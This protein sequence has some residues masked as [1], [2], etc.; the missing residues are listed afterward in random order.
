[1][2]TRE[3]VDA[4]SF[5]LP[6]GATASGD[7]IAL[8]IGLVPVDVYLDF[9]CP[10]CK[11]FQ[12]MSGATLEG[13]LGDGAITLVHHPVNLLDAVSTTGYSTRAAAA[14]AAASDF[15]RFLEYVEALLL[16]QPPED[17]PGLT[18]CQL[19]ELGHAVGI[20]DA[21][22]AERVN[23]GRYLPWPPYVTE[24]ATRR[25]VS[26]TPTVYVHGKP[27]AARPGPIELA[28]RIRI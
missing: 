27:V 2:D 8:G 14:S 22:F 4:P 11:Q 9:Q 25:G 28:V 21:G 18:D 13:L 26:G 12:L 20:T 23:L 24:R 16:N 17:G 6:K 1:M 5:P 7:G 15:D 19:V 3:P 10:V